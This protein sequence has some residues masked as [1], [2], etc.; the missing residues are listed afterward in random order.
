[1]IQR[2]SKTFALSVLAATAARWGIPDEEHYRLLGV[3]KS[4]SDRWFAELARGS[5][6]GSSFEAPVLDRISHIVSIYD[7]LHRLYVGQEA[8]LWISRSN[9]AFAGKAP[10]ELLL[11]G[12]LE[13]LLE[14]RRYVEFFYAV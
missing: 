12:K 1:M 9:A 10:R 6:N 2:I 5:L 3:S 8:N 14:V 7:M 4:T 11:S 13:D